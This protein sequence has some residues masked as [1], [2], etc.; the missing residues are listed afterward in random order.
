MYSVMLVC[1][2]AAILPNGTFDL[3][4]AGIVDI[5]VEDPLANATEITVLL[6]VFGSIVDVGTHRAEISLIDADGHSTGSRDL[7]IT[8]QQSSHP[9][10]SSV[11]RVLVGLGDHSV[12]LKVDGNVCAQ[13][14]LT[15]SRARG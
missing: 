8:L 6:A 2:K 13:C 12:R 15:V 3:H 5:L 4:Q 10:W 1:S 9:R 7:E 11:L 14:D